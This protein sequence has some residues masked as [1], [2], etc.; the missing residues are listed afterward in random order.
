LFDS[1]ASAAN[2]LDDYLGF[3]C[4]LYGHVDASFRELMRAK[5]AT[6]FRSDVRREVLGGHHGQ[7]SK[8]MD[9]GLFGGEDRVRSVLGEATKKD[10]LLKKTIVQPQKYPNKKGGGSRSGK[11]GTTPS[12][13][14]RRRRSRS[15]SPH[16]RAGGS[17]GGRASGGG[18]GQYGS[19][20]RPWN[21]GDE[22]GSPK[23]AGKKKYKAGKGKKPA[24]T[25]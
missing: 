9:Q 14:S 12:A 25:E 22:H 1:T 16:S 4:D 23:P 21:D 19:K 10:D 2:K 6:L 13:T 5:M 15:R 20:K 24:K 18:S 17:R 3:Y 7:T 8:E 11:R